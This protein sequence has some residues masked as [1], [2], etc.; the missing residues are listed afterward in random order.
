M[1]VHDLGEEFQSAYC[2]GHRIETA[3]LKV[4]GD[5][6]TITKRACS[7]LGAASDTVN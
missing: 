5:I 7:E 2:S 6:L 3:L 1:L 4:K